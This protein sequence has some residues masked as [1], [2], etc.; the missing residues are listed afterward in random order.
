MNSTL[1]SVVPLAMFLSYYV[2]EVIL[3]DSL[4]RDTSEN[5]GTAPGLSWGAPEKVRDMVFV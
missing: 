4:G 2:S 5:K 1:G 3:G